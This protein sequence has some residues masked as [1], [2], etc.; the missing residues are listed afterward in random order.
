MIAG[1]LVLPAMA[2]RWWAA[3]GARGAEAMQFEET[4]QGEI[5]SLALP[6]DSVGL[7]M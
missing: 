3:R 4:E 6:V 2:L 7:Q 5:V 1:L